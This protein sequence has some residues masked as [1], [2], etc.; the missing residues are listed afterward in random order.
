M[1]STALTQRGSETAPCWNHPV[2]PAQRPEEAAVLDALSKLRAWSPYNG[3]A[4]LDDVADA[5]DTVAPPEDRIEELAQRLRG[6]LMQLVAI[7]ASDE[8]ERRDARAA[9]RIIR[10]REIREAEMPGDYRQAIGHLRQMGWVVNELLDLLV[11]LGCV[12][13]P[14][15]LNEAA[16]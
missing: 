10:A 3:D 13:S 4:W 5:L 15:S 12:K 9:L 11:E 6:Y 2:E 14:D 16:L 1:A 7:A 8:I